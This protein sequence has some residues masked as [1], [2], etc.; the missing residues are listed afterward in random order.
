[1]QQMVMP[2]AWVRQAPRVSNVCR[3]DRAYKGLTQV[4]PSLNTFHST[5]LFSVIPCENKERCHAHTYERDVGMELLAWSL[6]ALSFLYTTILHLVSV[7]SHCQTYTTSQYYV[8]RMGCKLCHVIMPALPKYCH[9][10]TLFFWFS[11][12]S[13]LHLWS[14]TPF[15]FFCCQWSTWRC[16]E[17][18]M[19]ISTLLLSND[20]RCIGL[21]N[22]PACI[23][24]VTWCDK[25][26]SNA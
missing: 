1:M 8:Q 6:Y 2:H 9:N 16:L 12:L 4:T 18:Q 19:V 13:S 25:M 20:G 24:S 5:L 23:N 11:A 17:R 26:A 3:Q 10:C 14:C 22:C 7:F 15:I 21:E